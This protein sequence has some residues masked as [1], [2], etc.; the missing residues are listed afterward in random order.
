MWI[1]FSIIAA[2][3]WAIV[4][5]IDKYILT[6]WI[7]QPFI[8][9]IVLGVI[10]LIAAIAVYFIYG[11]S[12]LSYFHI[13]LALLAGGAFILMAVFY[14]KA[15]KL[16]EASRVIPLLFLSSLFISIFSAFFLGEI[17]TPLKYLGI[18]LLVG[19]AILISSK[20]ISKI[21]VGKPFWLM[22]ISV[23][24]LSANRLLAKYLLNFADYWTIFAWIRIG[25]VL[26]LLPIIYIYLPDLI[27]VAKKYRGKVI[28]VM[29]GNE[30]VNLGG[31]LLMIIA[32]SSGYITLVNSLTAVQ[33]FFV[34]LLAVIVS[35]FYPSILK[36]EI[37]KSVVAHK[38]L[39][40]VLL[41][42]GVIL[43]T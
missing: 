10:G 8:P 11:L 31:G 21:A 42:I 40:I 15:L 1:L 4:N 26:A 12:P 43:V 27:R 9:V 29:A 30:I 3:C 2:L 13:L 28:G 38:F 36:E 14:F 18:I 19:G 7:R 20:Q 23:L 34:L 32:I 22:I 24:A 33:P 6:K 5:I 41:F 39:A 37:K 35:T 17:F 16:E 25:A